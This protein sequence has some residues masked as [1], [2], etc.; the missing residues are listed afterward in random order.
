MSEEREESK[1][2]TGADQG[3]EGVPRGHGAGAMQ[4]HSEQAAEEGPA[5]TQ[6]QKNVCLARGRGGP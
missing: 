6:G 2:A 1:T 4:A 5:A 3:R